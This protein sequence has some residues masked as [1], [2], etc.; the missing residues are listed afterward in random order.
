M[1]C[2]EVDVLIVG[3]GPAGSMTAMETSKSGLSTLQIEQNPEFGFIQRCGE[4][5]LQKQLQ[6]YFPPDPEFIRTTIHKARFYAPGGIWA[7]M[8]K[9]NGGYILDRQK[10]DIFIAKKAK[11]NGTIQWL[12]SYPVKID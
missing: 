8:N 1:E 6:L 4:G 11:Q 5:V 9:P 2:N 12:N 10:F 3:G 7:E